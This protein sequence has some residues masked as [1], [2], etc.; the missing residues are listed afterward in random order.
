MSYD[1]MC[2]KAIF[3][4]ACQIPNNQ[5]SV[6]DNKYAWCCGGVQITI[7]D[8]FQITDV[9]AHLWLIDSLIVNQVESTL[10]QQF[11]ILPHVNNVSNSIQAVRDV[12]EDWHQAGRTLGKAVHESQLLAPDNA[13]HLNRE[14][15]SSMGFS[16]YPEQQKSNIVNSKRTQGDDRTQRKKGRE[17]Y[18]ENRTKEMG[19][20]TEL[21][22][23]LLMEGYKT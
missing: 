15:C 1:N 9:C 5:K 10:G 4:N 22:L 19:R 23:G 21:H 7:A 2:N 13:F 12:A 20:R 14:P 18:Q 3:R 16:I 17:K 11:V 8:V 6:R